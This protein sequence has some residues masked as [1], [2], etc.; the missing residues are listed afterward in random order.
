MEA[1]YGLSAQMVVRCLAKIGDSYKLNRTSRRQFSKHGSIAYDDRIL[2]LQLDHQTVS[3]WT[4]DG[5]IKQLLLVA[6]E[7]QRQS[8]QF[9]QGESDLVYWKGTS[10]LLVTC[11]AT[12]TSQQQRTLTMRSAL[13]LASVNPVTDSDEA[14]RGGTVE[15]RRQGTPVAVQ[16]CSALARR[17][18]NVA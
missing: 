2:T 3:I 11:N 7:R 16:Q 12:L 13:T 17:A 9:R 15:Q 10:F 18:P 5:R 6:G 1:D 4:V 14:H 8:P